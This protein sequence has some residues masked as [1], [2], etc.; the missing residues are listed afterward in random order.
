[1]I[2]RPMGPVAVFGA[3]NFPLALPTAAARA[4]IH[5]TGTSGGVLSLIQ[6]GDRHLGA[7]FAT[8]R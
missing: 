5:W 4:A 1:M 3:S 6:R 8:L 2:Q 7:A